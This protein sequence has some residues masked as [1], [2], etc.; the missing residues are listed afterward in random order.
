MSPIAENREPLNASI[1]VEEDWYSVCIVRSYLFWRGG[2]FSPRLLIA[3]DEEEEIK[4]VSFRNRRL[5]RG[6][7][8]EISGERFKVIS[9]KARVPLIL[10]SSWSI[11]ERKKRERDREKIFLSRFLNGYKYRESKRYNLATG[12]EGIDPRCSTATWFL[13]LRP[14]HFLHL[15]ITGLCV[16]FFL[17]FF[18]DFH[19]IFNDTI[20]FLSCQIFTGKKARQD[21]AAFVEISQCGTIENIFNI[22]YLVKKEKNY[23]LSI[24]FLFKISS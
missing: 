4:T 18:K 11:R 12:D 7:P 24:I 15:R 5:K 22:Y 10:P 1:R 2:K 14:R 21:I 3:A 16:S 13:F 19:S 8:V 17:S 23:F 9:K 20:R 6:R